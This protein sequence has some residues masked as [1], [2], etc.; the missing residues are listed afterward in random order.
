MVLRAKWYMISG[1]VETVLKLSP[2][3]YHAY[4]KRFGRSN[5]VT[6]F[7]VCVRI[8]VVGISY[9]FNSPPENFPSIDPAFC[10]IRM[11]WKHTKS[12]RKI[13]A[14]SCCIKY[15]ISLST[16]CQDVTIN[17]LGRA[18]FCRF[19]FSFFPAMQKVTLINKW[20]RYRIIKVLWYLN[21]LI[22]YDSV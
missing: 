11:E 8:F 17:F 12:K 19:L 6:N 21:L 10:F 7:N 16:F 13:F 5:G 4:I 3:F 9:R 22:C 18:Q 1:S 2:S 14:F 15:A 20:C